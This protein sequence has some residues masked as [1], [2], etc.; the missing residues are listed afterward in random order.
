VRMAA[1][2]ETNIVAVERIKEYSEVE[3]EAEWEQPKTKPDR[4]WPQDG[5]VQF[6]K[7]G[8]RYREGLDL[9]LRGI[10][11]RLDSAEKIGI[12][13]RT[14]AGKSSLT[15]ALFRLVEA[16][17]GAITIDGI[18]ISKLGLHNLRNQLTIIPQDPVL[19]SGTLRMNLDPF[20]QYSDEEVW[21]ALKQSHLY[22]YAS[23]LQ[24]GL[25]HE[26]TEGGGNISVG[27]RQLVCL[28]RALLRKTKVLILDEATA[29]VDLETD[30]LIQ[31]TIRR[32]F[33]DCTIIT[34]AHRL[35]TIMDS[36]R[37]LVLDKGV[38]EE[39]DSPDNLLKDKSSLFYSMA[40]DAALVN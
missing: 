28:A 9:V 2:L 4:T 34:I 15:L 17:E 19:F 36:D 3:T 13:G 12:V 40:K 8:T 21:R 20:D 1:E 33:A 18:D 35:N 37:V 27:Q 6:D 7:Y 16:A 29:A 10:D 5:V 39:F 32:E 14:G 38:I 30:E 24:S 26:V 25:L 23:S 22:T 31:H 11:C